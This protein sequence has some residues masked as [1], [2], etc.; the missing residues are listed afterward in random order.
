VK[1]TTNSDIFRK[2]VYPVY[3]MEYKTFMK[4]MGF[5]GLTEKI[6]E[7]QAKLGKV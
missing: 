1:I 2:Y 5:R 6:K 7:E 3:K 4:I